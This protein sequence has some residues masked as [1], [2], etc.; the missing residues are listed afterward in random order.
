MDKEFFEELYKLQS[1]FKPKN[2][3]NKDINI[4]NRVANEILKID[5]R[6]S[7]LENKELNLLY[8]LNSSIDLLCDIGCNSVSDKVVSLLNG[9]NFE[10]SGSES[11]V[12]FITYAKIINTTG[13]MVAKKTMSIAVP[14]IIND[15]SDVF[16][17][18]E[19]SHSLKEENPFE[20]RLVYNLMEMIPMLIELIAGYNK[21][22]ITFREVIIGRFNLLHGEAYFFKKIMSEIK[23]YSGDKIPAYL[24]SALGSTIVYLNSFYYTLALFYTYLSNPEYIIQYINL[25]LNCSITSE[26]VIKNVINIGLVSSFDDEFNLGLNYLKKEL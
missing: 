4:A 11:P 3:S 12:Q 21:G 22:L 8:I 7:Q 26:D 18:H 15:V 17:A 1:S 9:I 6:D 23:K 24:Y 25:V 5:Y 2:I 13:G 14:G 10:L 19:I 16:V 20:C